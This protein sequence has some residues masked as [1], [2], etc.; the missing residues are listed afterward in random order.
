MGMGAENDSL[1]WS[2][3]ESFLSLSA[4]DPATP[5]TEFAVLKQGI[6]LL[7]LLGQFPFLLQLLVSWKPALSFLDCMRMRGGE[8]QGTAEEKGML[9]EMTACQPHGGLFG[10]RKSYSGFSFSLLKTFSTIPFQGQYPKKAVKIKA[11]PIRPS[12][13]PGSPETRKATT[14]KT[15]PRTIRKTASP[16]FTFF[17]LVIE[18]MSICPQIFVDV[19]LQ[20]P[21]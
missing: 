2:P 7:D 19:R 16:R 6:G 15:A 8:E 1:Q 5:R 13:S 3:T 9:D 12:T 20:P 18:T 10:R 11:A 21:A 17:T 14:I 4:V